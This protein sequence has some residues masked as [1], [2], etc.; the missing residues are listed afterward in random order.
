[1]T[2]K[3]RRKVSLFSARECPV[4]VHEVGVNQP[5]VLA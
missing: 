3:L 2:L 4:M 5:F 1:M